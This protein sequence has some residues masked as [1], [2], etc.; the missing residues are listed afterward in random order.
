MSKKTTEKKYNIV[1]KK[2][3]VILVIIIYMFIQDEPFSTNDTVINKGPIVNNLRQIK[4]AYNSC[5]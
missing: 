4:A 3:S 2:A 5:I 1:K